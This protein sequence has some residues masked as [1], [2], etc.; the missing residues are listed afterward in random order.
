MS[1]L[2]D[3]FLNDHCCAKEDGAQKKMGR[4]VSEVTTTDKLKTFL[5]I[6]SNSVI[7]S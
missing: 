2:K 6:P 7:P 5:L 3:D 1:I 4:K